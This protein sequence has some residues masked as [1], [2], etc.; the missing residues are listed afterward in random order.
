MSELD[1]LQRWSAQYEARPTQSQSS[2]TTCSKLPRNPLVRASCERSDQCV[3]PGTF[4]NESERKQQPCTDRADSL[5]LLLHVLWVTCILRIMSAYHPI[6]T[7]ASAARH[8]TKAVLLRHRPCAAYGSVWMGQGARA[9]LTLRFHSHH[10]SHSHG[11]DKADSERPS[12]WSCG[13]CINTFNLF[14]G[15]CEYIQPL[16]DGVNFFELLQMW[17]LEWRICHGRS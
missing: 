17:V 10:A 1:C 7:L 8:Q 6:A 9:A 4:S 12:C 5:Q 13:A 11:V 2:T 3:R 16:D 14:C 15:K